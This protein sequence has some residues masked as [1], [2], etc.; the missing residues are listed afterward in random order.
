MLDYP[1][2]NIINIQSQKQGV[3][4]HATEGALDAVLAQLRAELPRRQKLGQPAVVHPLV[5]GVCGVEMCIIHC[6]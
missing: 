1:S 3:R 4:S 6:S 5:D 2:D